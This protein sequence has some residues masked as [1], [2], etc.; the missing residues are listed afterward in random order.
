MWYPQGY[1][2]GGVPLMLVG[3]GKGA[4]G[5][6]IRPGI[7]MLE[8]SSKTAHGLAL[9]C[10]GKEGIVGSVQRRVRQPGL[11]AR[12]LED[13]LSMEVRLKLLPHNCAQRS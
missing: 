11:S 7:G 6:M 10:L 3:F 2:L 9:A 5:V 8:A 13:S 12:L 4:V 1:N